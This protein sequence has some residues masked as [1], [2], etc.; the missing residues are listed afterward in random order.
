MLVVLPS[1]PLAQLALCALAKVAKIA[2]SRRQGVI[3]PLEVVVLRLQTLRLPLGHLPLVAARLIHLSHVPLQ[4]AALI[5]HTVSLVFFA[6][7]TV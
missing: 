1:M 5:P 6:S 4:V 3:P 7:E 2:H